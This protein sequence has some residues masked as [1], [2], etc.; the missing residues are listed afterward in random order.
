MDDVVQHLKQ[1]QSDPSIRAAVI[2]S[3]KPGCFIAGADITMLSKYAKV[4]LPKY[5]Y[6]YVLNR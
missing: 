5:A 2:I 6:A 3:A 4:F 1:I